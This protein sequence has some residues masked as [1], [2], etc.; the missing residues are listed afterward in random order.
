LP[1]KPKKSLGQHFLT[2]YNIIA[3]ILDSIK[4]E[5]GAR[6]I[7]IGSGTGPLTRWHLQPYKDVHALEVD[8][9]AIHVSRS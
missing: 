9:R 1:F 3:K 4:I 6:I 8:E 2:D 5:Q 7:E